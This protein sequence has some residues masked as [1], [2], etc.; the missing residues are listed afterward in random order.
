[1]K[2]MFILRAMAN[3]AGTERVMSDKINWLAERGHDVSLVTYE[4]GLHPLSFALHSS[5]KYLDINTRFFM[6][7]SFPIY[8]RIW[9][10]RRLKKQFLS[11][12]Q[13]VVDK[14]CPDVIIVTSYSL[15]VITEILKIRTEARKI[16]ESHVACY[17][18]S[19]VY[20]YRSNRIMRKVV[21]LYDKY[22]YRKVDVFDLLL[23]LT[24][25]DKKDWCQFVHKVKAIPNP[26][27]YYPEQIP[28]KSVFHR[29]ICV[30]RLNEQKGFDLLID[31]FSLVASQCPEW[32]IDIFGHG[33]EERNLLDQ[34]Y[35]KGLEH[36]VNILKPTSDIYAEYLQSDFFVL[37]SRYEGF[38]LVLIEA[39]S[40]GIPCV[41]FNCNYGPNE[42]IEDGING[43]LVNN[44]D[45]NCLAEKMLW[46]MTH[47]SKRLEMGKK[48]HISVSK[49]GMDRVMLQWE[50]AYLSA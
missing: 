35:R 39:M 46:M 34:I 10:Y 3:V 20:D 30:G 19:K 26:L 27:T 33:E 38:G 5:V 25:G 47:E 6:L 28:T 18:V 7:S 24:E 2:I 23:V 32:H 15:N 48:A 29:I 37:S 40:C 41:A 49:Y 50:Q 17:S 8:C 11:Q 43:I 16:M 31:A 45:V 1:M 12:L 21:Q 4:Q 36:R 42:I 14:M 13:N 44:G 22:I 9:K